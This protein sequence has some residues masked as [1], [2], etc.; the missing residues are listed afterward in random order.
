MLPVT[1]LGCFC[2]CVGGR[3]GGGG[4]REVFMDGT[5]CHG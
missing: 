1:D 4:A 2:R 5:T 3:W